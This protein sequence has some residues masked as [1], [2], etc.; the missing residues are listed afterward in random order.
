MKNTSESFVVFASSYMFLMR[1]VFASF[2]APYVSY[3]SMCISY[4]SYERDVPDGTH[5]FLCLSCW[6]TDTCCC[7]ILL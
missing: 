5:H 7:S 4:V 2:Y 3:V 1:L 6:L